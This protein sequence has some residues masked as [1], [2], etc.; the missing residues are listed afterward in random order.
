MKHVL[1][2]KQFYID[3]ILEGIKNFEIR[4]NDRGFQKGDLIRFQA[5]T[6]DFIPTSISG[7]PINRRVYEITYVHSGLGLKENYVVFGIKERTD[8]DVSVEF[9]YN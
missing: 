6:N 5:V 1:K 3:S 2:I 8:L 4:L 9:D 7:S